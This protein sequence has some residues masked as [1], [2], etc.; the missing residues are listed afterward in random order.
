ME[1]IQRSAAETEMA[2]ATHGAPAWKTGL[3]GGGSS[4]PAEHLRSLRSCSLLGGV[5]K[6]GKQAQMPAI[7]G[8][9]PPGP[10]VIARTSWLAHPA[11]AGHRSLIPSSSRVWH[12]KQLLQVWNTAFLCQCWFRC[13]SHARWSGRR[14]LALAACTTGP[15]VRPAREGLPPRRLLGA[16]ERCSHAGGRTGCL[17]PRIA[18]N[19]PP[20][21]P[22]LPLAA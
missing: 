5:V 7:C 20:E 6:F 19:D 15:A 16:C 9:R 4:A 3:A 14:F 10:R 12:Y 2:A 8:Q 13:L 21:S 22:S 17:V 18:R 11:N 1:A